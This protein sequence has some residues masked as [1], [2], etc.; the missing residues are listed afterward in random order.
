MKIPFLQP[1]VVTSLCSFSDQD[2]GGLL[3]LPEK[4]DLA[5]MNIGEVL[6]V[7]NTLLSVAAREVSPSYLPVSFASC[8]YEHTTRLPVCPDCAFLLH[9]D[10][11]FQPAL[12][13]SEGAFPSCPFQSA[14]SKTTRMFVKTS[15]NTQGCECRGISNWGLN[16]WWHTY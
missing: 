6:A 10:T 7:M 12:Q 9:M 2:P 15:M 11:G 13:T 1:G 5:S 4:S 8:S 14:G 3:L 16:L